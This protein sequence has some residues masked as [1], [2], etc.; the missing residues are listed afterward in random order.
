MSGK[1]GGLAPAPTRITSVPFREWPLR[2]RIV[3]RLYRLLHNGQ[4]RT[5]VIR[6]ERD[7]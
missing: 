3:E 7:N 2:A 1:S 5:L 6:D 4:I